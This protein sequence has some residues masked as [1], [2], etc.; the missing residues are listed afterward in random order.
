[1]SDRKRKIVTRRMGRLGPLVAL[2]A[3]LAA[4]GGGTSAPAAP[5]P[6]PA[7]D[8]AGAAPSV[9]VIRTDSGPGQVPPTPLVYG[10]DL[11][12]VK[13]G[14]FDQGKMWTFEFPPTRYFAST[15]GFQ[16]DSSWFARARLGALRI[17]SCSAS[18]VSP[19][20][21]VMTNHHCAREFVTQVQKDGEDLLDDGFIATDLADEREVTDFKADQ[22]IDIVDVTD[23]VNAQLD[24]IPLDAR[25]EARKDV[26]DGI[27][28]RI[29]E[30]R[31]G[32]D[33]GIAVEM[34][35]LYDGARTSAYVFHRYTHAKLVM[36]PEVQIGFFGGDPD[37]FTYPR[38]NLDF[39]FFRLY[40]D[41]GNPLKSDH[42]FKVDTTGLHQGEPIF[43]VGNPGSTSRLQTVAQLEL[44]R[45]VSDRALQDVLRSR[46]KVLSDYM[47][48]HPEEAKAVDLENHYFELSNSEK[49]YAGQ[50]RGLEDPVIMARRRDT[51]RK[52][53][54][55]IDADPKLKAQYGDVIQR[56]ADIQ[57]EKR[58]VKDETE[59]FV[60]FGN[61]FIDASTILRAFW[62]TQVII[63]RRNGASPDDL[64]QQLAG[65][66]SV[67]QLPEG[68]DAA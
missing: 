46:M 53:Q 22:L 59:A 19:N 15:Y 51:Q 50:V 55:A 60:G 33:A 25:T 11:D 26:L 6:A 18:F 27:Q 12:T 5:A 23:E 43:I 32:E 67:P 68:L 30:A 66:D 48:S 24:T 39:S 44:R 34:V 28:K 47:A 7:A 8:T 3:L 61:P 17:P 37:N 38:Y 20:G 49:A 41:D 13:A 52:L 2:A 63:M 45:D 62:A 31:G 56:I 10:V 54:D 4:C 40:D 36:V 35:S 21:L 14:R 64:E 65:L 58:A 9:P 42:Y 1:M 57:K 16:P 29:E